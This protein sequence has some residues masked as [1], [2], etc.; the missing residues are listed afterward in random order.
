MMIC[1]IHHLTC[2]LRFIDTVKEGLP[3]GRQVLCHEHVRVFS[4]TPFTIDLTGSTR[5]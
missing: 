4:D 2:L 5:R 1:I 3:I